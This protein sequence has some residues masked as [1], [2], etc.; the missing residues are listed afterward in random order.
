MSENL[1]WR[2]EW[3]S[4]RGDIIVLVTPLKFTFKG[5]EYEIP[6]G[7]ESDG[8]SVPRFFW[9]SLSPKI[10]AKTLIPSVIHDFMYENHIG[11]R[12]EAD[13]FYEQNLIEKGFGRIKSWLVWFGVRIGG[14]KHY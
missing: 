11:T 5:V 1:Y 8:M 10:N 2:I 4:E 3:D 14:W 9:R 12:A 7:Y 13:E 6:A